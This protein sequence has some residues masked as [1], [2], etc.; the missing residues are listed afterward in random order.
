LRFCGEF[1]G[2]P[3]PTSTV[4]ASFDSMG[5]VLEKDLRKGIAKKT[6]IPEMQ[7]KRISSIMEYP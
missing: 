4:K 6:T 5:E 3:E 7:R 2:M 1:E